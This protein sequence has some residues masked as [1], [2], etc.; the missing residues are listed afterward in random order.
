MPSLA[1][2][3]S[4]VPDFTTLPAGNYAVMVDK[5]ELRES[6]NNPGSYYLNWTFVVTEGEYTNRQIWMTSGLTEKSLWRLKAVFKNLGI[7]DKFGDNIEIQIDDETLLMTY[8]P[9]AGCVAIILLS[10]SPDDKGRMQNNVEEVLPMPVVEQPAPAA[11]A[12]LVF[13]A[14]AAAVQSQPTAPSATAPA[15]PGA[16]PA[17]PTRPAP[18]PAGQA[19]RPKGPL[20]LK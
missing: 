19:Q 20:N 6:K 13:K 8:P 3:F 1:I 7:L 15:A 16:G 5:C 10:E 14:P 11:P 4:E 18:V 9:V 2:N 17:T 12:G